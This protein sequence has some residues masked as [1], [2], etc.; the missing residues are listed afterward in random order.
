MRD[1]PTIASVNPLVQE[2]AA[3][4]RLHGPQSTQFQNLMDEAV[5]LP[6][7]GDI[8]CMSC[9][10]QGDDGA[11]MACDMRHH[12]AEGQI[13]FPMAEGPD[14]VC[15]TAVLAVP[16][17]GTAAEIERLASDAAAVDA[18][19]SG[20]VRHGMFP[21]GTQVSMLRRALYLADL[22][23]ISPD[24]LHALRNT[25]AVIAFE[26]EHAEEDGTTWR[27][28]A[29]GAG[30]SAAGCEP[31]PPDIGWTVGYL[32]GVRVTPVS[33]GDPPRP[34]E[35]QIEAMLDRALAAWQD[36]ARD[37]LEARDL[38]C[39]ILDPTHADDAVAE[40]AGGLIMTCLKMEFLG[41]HPGSPVPDPWEAMNVYFWDDVFAVA[42]DHDGESFGPIG[43]PAA[44]LGSSMEGLIESI[45]A[46]ADETVLHEAG[47]CPAVGLRH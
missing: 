26:G 20:M 11:R 46:R 45:S 6:D 38:N 42:A 39:R 43:F 31:G 18:V 22:S 32:V 34:D 35:D 2:I 3:A 4:W 10:T 36:E 14:Q 16:I 12:V 44:L 30:A 37:I 25:L 29:E 33:E 23:Q 7:A 21:P 41:R 40:G 19:R 27:E 47:E 28:V 1:E 8:L 17:I 24:T 5:S 13:L 9:V 15:E